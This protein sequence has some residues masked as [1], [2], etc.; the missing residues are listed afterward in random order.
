M[1]M[2]WWLSYQCS[3]VSG[4]LRILAAEAFEWLNR[5]LVDATV[6]AIARWNWSKC[7]PR[8]PTNASPAVRARQV[9]LGLGGDFETSLRQAL[10]KLEH[11]GT[12]RVRFA[13]AHGKLTILGLRGISFSV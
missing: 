13:D 1:G 11:R 2:D 7:T 6:S 4:R 3:N 5:S 10:L 8:R 9:A 12:W